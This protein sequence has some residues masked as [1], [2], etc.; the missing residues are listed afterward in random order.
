[1]RFLEW[2]KN[3]LRVE[4]LVETWRRKRPPPLSLE[5]TVES[6]HQSASDVVGDV[7]FAFL[8]FSPYILSLQFLL[9]KPYMC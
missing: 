3:I 6:K 2:G 7:I 9:I 5:S 8:S 1:M 4:D